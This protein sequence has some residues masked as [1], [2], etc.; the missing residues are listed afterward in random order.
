MPITIHKNRPKRSVTDPALDKEKNI[1]TGSTAKSMPSL[2]PNTL[3]AISRLGSSFQ[4][5]TVSSSGS[6]SSSE[7]S[8]EKNENLNEEIAQVRYA[9][10]LF[11]NSRIKEAENLIMPNKETSLYWSLGYAFISFLKAMMTFQTSDIDTASEALKQ[12]IHIA[13]NAR[14]RDAGFVDS[15]TSWVKGSTGLAS[16]KSMTKLQR[17]AVCKFPFLFFGKKLY[18]Q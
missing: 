13:T 4:N 8:S 7:T 3:R 17:H 9:L 10:D 14:K 16:V 2:R 1:P 18:I 6:G 5:L 11:L 15:L 12:C